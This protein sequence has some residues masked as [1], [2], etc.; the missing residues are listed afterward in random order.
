L[1]RLQAAHRDRAEEVGISGTRLRRQRPRSQPTQP[2]LGRDVT[3]RLL[4]ARQVAEI[5]GVS[6]E[7]VLRW[8]R[9]GELPAV[10][11]PGGAIRYRG[12][13]LEQWLVARATQGR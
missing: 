7:T 1:D 6:A 13:A 10:R 3:G 11:L 4:P 9:R 8:T 2:L 12:D 5:L